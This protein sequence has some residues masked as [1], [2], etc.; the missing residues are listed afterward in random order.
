MRQSKTRGIFFTK[1]KTELENL[2]LKKMAEKKKVKAKQSHIS[3]GFDIEPLLQA[4]GP[5]G[6]GLYQITQMAL[7]LFQSFGVAFNILSVVFI[8]K[9]LQPLLYR[10]ISGGGELQI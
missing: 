3:D 7:Q 4:L 1:E 6:L 5:G 2:R 9:F 8:G 10:S